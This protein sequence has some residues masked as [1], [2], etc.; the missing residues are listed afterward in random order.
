ML[1]PGKPRV[2]FPMRSLDFSIDLILPAALW[3][4]YLSRYS[5]EM[6]CRGSIPGRG[7]KFSPLHSVQN[8]SGVHPAS[9]PKGTGSTF[10]GGKA[11][12]V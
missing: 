5:G 8:G 3:P 6:Y 12:G 9:Y 4:G 7:K 2:G 11:A 1:Q 10:P